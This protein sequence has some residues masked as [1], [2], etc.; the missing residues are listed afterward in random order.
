MGPGFFSEQLID[1]TK[2]DDRLERYKRGRGR[3]TRVDAL[4]MRRRNVRKR[5]KEDVGMQGLVYILESYER[6]CQ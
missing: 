2:I 4:W 6:Q 3:A 5:K 1:C